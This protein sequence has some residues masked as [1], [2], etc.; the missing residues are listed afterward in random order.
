MFKTYVLLMLLQPGVH[1]TACLP[2]VDLAALITP[3]V[4]S[5]KLSFTGRRKLDTFLGGRPTDLMLCRDS[6]LLRQNGYDW[7]IHRV[8]NRQPEDNPESVT[9]LSYVGTIFN[10]IN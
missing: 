4:L 1:G 2:N 3:G 6:T 10:R 5:P 9:F 7:Q 8:L